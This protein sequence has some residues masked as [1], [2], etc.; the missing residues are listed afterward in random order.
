MSLAVWLAAALLVQT[1]GSDPPAE[2]SLRY[3]INWPSGLSLGEASLDARRSAEGWQFAFALEAAVPGFEVR[4][5]YRSLAGESFCSLELEKDFR[6]GQ[7][8]GRERTSF[9]AQRGVAV[10]ETLEGGGKSELTAPLCP[11][12]A[13]TFLFFLRRELAQGRLPASTEVFFGARYRV[14]FEHLGFRT[15]RVNEVP[16]ETEGL[17]VGVK[18]PASEHTFEIYFVRDAVRTPALVRAAFPMGTFSME[19]VR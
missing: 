8:T 3:T 19:L 7:R 13:L 17:R 15:V 14:S 2:E 1:V 18:G 4:D 6:H 5:Q 12:D 16:T 11:R 10:R 9:D